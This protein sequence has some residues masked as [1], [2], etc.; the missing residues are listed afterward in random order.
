MW[1]APPLV[2]YLEGL[3]FFTSTPSSTGDFHHQILLSDLAK[4]LTCMSSG[5]DKQGQLLACYT[6]A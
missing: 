5:C 6:L 1:Y 3:I 2:V 4:M